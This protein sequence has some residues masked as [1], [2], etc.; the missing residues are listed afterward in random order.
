MAFHIL[1][2]HVIG[3]MV[4]VLEY[5]ALEFYLKYRLR[6]FQRKMLSKINKTYIIKAIKNILSNF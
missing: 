6:V 4:L 1:H 3:Q 2:V 5:N